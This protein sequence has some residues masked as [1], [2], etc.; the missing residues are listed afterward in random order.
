MYECKLAANAIANGKKRGPHFG[1]EELLA[2][3]P[4]NGPSKC[5]SAAEEL[6]YKI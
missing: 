5:H 2:E 6:V 1:L 4:F 3:E